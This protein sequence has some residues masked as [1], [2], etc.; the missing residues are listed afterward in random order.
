MRNSD[1]APLYRSAIGFDRLFNLLES[2]QNQSNG[3]YPPY[4]VELVDENNYRIAIAVAGFAEQELEITT[5]DNLLIVRGSHA[6]EPAQRTYLYQ[7]IAERNFERKFQL[8]EHIKIKGAN[9]VNGLLYI[10]LERL[11]PE[12]LKPRRIEIK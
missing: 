8:A 11:V 12:S 2:G 5:Q 6:N 1:L 10:D 9:L 3:G 7:G 4:N